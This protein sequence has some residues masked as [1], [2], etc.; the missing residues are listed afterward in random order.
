MTN[1]IENLSDE[2]Y[3][4]AACCCYRFHTAG[5]HVGEWYLP[6][7]GEMG[8]I[9]NRVV[10]INSS[11]EKII[12]F[13]G[14]IFSG[15]DTTYMYWTSCVCQNNPVSFRFGGNHDTVFLTGVYSESTNSRVR[16]MIKL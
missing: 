6:A 11:I 12:K 3:Y 14:D 7:A 16:A 10:T 8:Y 15:V 1:E 13:Y 5:T 4:P 2:G 9:I